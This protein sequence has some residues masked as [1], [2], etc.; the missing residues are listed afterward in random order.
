VRLLAAA[1]K[2]NP[3]NPLILA[4]LGWAIY[5]D[6]SQPEHERLDIGRQM[7][8]DADAIADNMAEPAMMLA[9]IDLREGMLKQAEQRLRALLRKDQANAEARQLLHEVQQARDG[10]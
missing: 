6:S 8:A 1:R 5:H 10:A 9:R 3:M 7:V 4:N 2:A